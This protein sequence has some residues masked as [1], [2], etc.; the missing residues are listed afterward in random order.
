MEILIEVMCFGFTF[1]SKQQ[2]GTLFYSSKPTSIFQLFFFSL[3]VSSYHG[4][5]IDLQIVLVGWL[6]CWFSFFFFFG[7]TGLKLKNIFFLLHPKHR[8]YKCALP[9]QGSCGLMLSNKVP[10]LLC[11]SIME[12]VRNYYA[13]CNH[14][15]FYFFM[16][17]I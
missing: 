3:Q 1:L 2:R 11:L 8:E 17:Y 5:L 13:I 14:Y 12:D 9:M 4:G 10:F 16:Q 6:V 15:C 7:L